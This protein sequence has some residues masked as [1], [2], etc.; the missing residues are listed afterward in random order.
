M[1]WKPLGTIYVVNFKPEEVILRR[2]WDKKRGRYDNYVTV[3]G[4]IVD[5]VVL[6]RQ[7]E[8]LDLP[9]RVTLLD[10]KRE[11]SFSNFLRRLGLK[12]QDIHS[13]IREAPFRRGRWEPVEGVEEAES[14]EAL[15]ALLK[16]KAQNIPQVIASFSAWMTATVKGEEWVLVVEPLRHEESDAMTFAP[17]KM[18]TGR[19]AKR[20]FDIAKEMEGAF[21]KLKGELE[22][23]YGDWSIDYEARSEDE[24]KETV[25]AAKITMSK[26]LPEGRYEVRIWAPFM[27]RNMAF[28]LS[29]HLNGV[30]VYP[31]APIKVYVPSVGYTRIYKLRVFHTKNWLQNLLRKI[32]F[33]TDP[34]LMKA[35]RATYE[36]LA[37]IPP[38]KVSEIIDSLE[39]SKLINPETADRLRRMEKLNTITFLRKIDVKHPGVQALIVSALLGEEEKEYEVEPRIGEKIEVKV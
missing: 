15:L 18:Y 36:K 3:R 23:R 30:H 19:E 38:E 12:K 11:K 29:A 2:R 6:G 31:T 8:E 4:K 22:A 7:E 32:E 34:K 5:Y 35:S 21:K 17:R 28:H 27:L 10:T 25:V 24:E 13:V 20:A 9:P 39:E 14:P 26:D 33:L 37:E 1:A 16:E